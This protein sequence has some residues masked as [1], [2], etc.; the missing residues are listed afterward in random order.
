MA[1]TA[2][3]QAA[4]KTRRLF[5]AFP[6]SESLQAYAETVQARLRSA[7]I[8]GRWT[9][10]ANLHVT[11][12]FL[13]EHPE[14][15]LPRLNE[16]LAAETARIPGLELAFDGIGC[17][18][19]PPKLLHLA[20]EDTVEGEFA[21]CAQTLMNAVETAGIRLG[22]EVRRRHPIPHITLI[23]F[24]L[25][26]DQRRLRELAVFRG[27]RLVWRDNT[28]TIPA[29]ETPALPCREINL[30]ESRLGPAG[31]VYRVL[32]TFPLTGPDPR[33]SA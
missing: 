9:R 5:L 3:N 15:L 6:V 30:Y 23:R 24:H 12:V 22:P 26:R 14:S 19:W 7:G 28:V 20:L 29:P 33:S 13:G 2:N 27:G 32:D 1:S 25:A 17:F 21:R 18:N 16:R 31:A 10:P 4:A 8:R 11:V